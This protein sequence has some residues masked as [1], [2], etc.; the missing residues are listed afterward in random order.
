MP[1]IL[2]ESFC[3]RCGTRYTFESA[4]PRKT[5]RL[6]GFKTLSKGLKN[7]VLSDDTSM[8]EAMAAARSD[9]ERETTAQQLDAFHATFNFCMNCRQYTCGNCWNQAEGRCLTCSPFLGRDILGSPFPDEEPFEEPFEAPA[10]ELASDLPESDLLSDDESFAFSEL[11][12]P[13]RESL[14]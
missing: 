2:T 4:A 5:R 11:V 13:A 10:E 12:A 8:D 3:E 9:L 14:R 6:G 1:E 7:Y